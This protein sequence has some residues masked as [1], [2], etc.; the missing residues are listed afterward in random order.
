MN[1]RLKRYP[2]AE[3]A[4]DKAEQLSTKQDDKEYI[5]FLRG[6][7]FERQKRYA[8]AEVQFKKVIASDPQHAMALNYL[9]YML[10]DQN[11]K[12]D[13]ASDTSSAHST[14]THQRRLPR[15]HRMGLFPPRQT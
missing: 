11:T 3:Q 15:F 5:W 13:E 8:E 14:S 1:T 7:T 10:A 4:L 6:S 12:L 2:E 9:G